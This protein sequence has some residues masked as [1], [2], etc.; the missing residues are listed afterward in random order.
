MLEIKNVSKSF[1]GLKALKGISFTIDEKR[2]HGIIGPNGSGKTTLF[3]CITGML[4]LTGGEVIHKGQIISGSPPHEIANQGIRRTFQT[5]K[6]VPSLSVLEN[7]MSGVYEF[8]T[9]DVRDIFLRLPFRQSRNE[10]KLQEKALEV[11]GM[12]GI[13]AIADKWASE[14]VWA[15]RQ[16]VQIARAIMSKPG[17]LLLDEPA[18]GMGPKET[19]QVGNLIQRIKEMGITPVVVSHDMKMM[20]NIAERV[21]VLNFGDLISQGTPEEIQ[22][23]PKVLE[24][25]LGA[26]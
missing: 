18:S 15:E 17:I 5:A 9:Q 2:I 12:L 23:D 4:P 10:K 14:L 16:F 8:G 20:M 24:A 7:V 22:K 3:N 21:T 25:Y 26:E 19:E 11:L 1:G 13:A 6:L